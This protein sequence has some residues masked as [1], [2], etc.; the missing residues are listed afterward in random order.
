MNKQNQLEVGKTVNVF[1]EFKPDEL[2]D[3]VIITYKFVGSISLMLK[4]KSLK[5]HPGKEIEFLIIESSNSDKFIGFRCL[6]LFEDPFHNGRKCYSEKGP[7][8]LI[9][10]HKGFY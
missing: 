7:V 4:T 10:M 2:I 8:Y 3:Q 9:S 1:D 5:L 6:I